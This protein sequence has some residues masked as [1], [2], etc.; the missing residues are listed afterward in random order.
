M[1]I[2]FAGGG[3]GGHLFPGLA[4]ARSLKKCH[5]YISIIF[6]GARRGMEKRV[7]KD[8]FQFRPIDVVGL[9]GGSIWAKVRGLFPLAKGIVQSCKVIWDLKPR[10]VLGLGGFSAGPV[11]LAAYVQGVPVVLHEQNIVPG[12]TNRLLAPMARKIFVS[13]SATRSR[14][15]EKKTFL[16]GNPVRPELFAAKSNTRTDKFTVLVLGGSQGSRFI[17]QTMP[18]TVNLL[19]NHGNDVAVTHQTGEADFENTVSAY[20]ELSLEA[21]VKPFIEDMGEAYGKADLIIARAGAT[22]IAEVTALGKAA[23]FIPFPYATHNHQEKNARSIEEKGACKVLLEG[24]TNHQILADTIGQ[25]LD[26][27]DQ[28]E[29]MR[30][31][32]S[33]IGSHDATSLITEALGEYVK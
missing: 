18:K 23:L 13:F 11:G 27:P 24:E 19:K 14:F 3:T 31:R 20:R 10:F 16:T 28:L 30:K 2:I 5:P 1:T 4:V 26:N 21:L 12:V 25:L 32:S 7:L 33:E 15:P 9:A 17:N 6:V 29:F 8:E 22:T